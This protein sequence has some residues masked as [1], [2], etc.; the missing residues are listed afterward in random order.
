VEEDRAKSLMMED[1]NEAPVVWDKLREVK[2]VNQRLNISKSLAQQLR[3]TREATA[4]AQQLVSDPFAQLDLDS[5]SRQPATGACSTQ[6]PRPAASVIYPTHLNPH[7]DHRDVPFATSGWK[8]RLLECRARRKVEQ[9]TNEERQERDA[10]AA[11]RELNARPKYSAPPNCVDFGPSACSTSTTH[12]TAYTKSHN[13]A[14]DD[15]ATRGASPKRRAPVEPRRLADGQHVGIEQCTDIYGAAA[16]GSWKR[17]T[18][19]SHLMQRI[20]RDVATA[21]QLS[22]TEGPHVLLLTGNSAGR[23]SAAQGRATRPS[24]ATVRSAATGL[25]AADQRC[26]SAAAPH[27]PSSSTALPAKKGKSNEISL[28]A[29][30]MKRSGVTFSNT[31]RGATGAAVDSKRPLSASLDRSRHASGGA[32]VR[33]PPPAHASDVKELRYK[34]EVSSVRNLPNFV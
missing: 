30:A 34:L 12:Y 17:P 19:A 28:Y 16:D 27:P 33:P 29:A 25:T 31:E 26:Q 18:T 3:T 20:H 5:S 8:L 21:Q 13:D 4:M 24:S 32:S 11:L 15:A 14:L 2:P 9:R 6:S 7:M 23:S 10:A 22:K 1:K